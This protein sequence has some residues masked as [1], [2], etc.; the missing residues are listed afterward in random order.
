MGGEER[1]QKALPLVFIIMN[2]SVNGVVLT[3][4]ASADEYIL[5]SYIPPKHA[6]RRPCAVVIIPD[7]SEN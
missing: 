4:A 7:L 6:I 5:E 2:T 1:R 3:G